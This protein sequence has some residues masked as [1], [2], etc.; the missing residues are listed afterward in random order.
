MRGPY[1]RED[2]ILPLLPSLPPSLP[3]PSPYIVNA[4]PTD[5]LDILVTADSVVLSWATSIKFAR[6][7]GIMVVMFNV[8]ISPA[9]AQTPFLRTVAGG[10]SDVVTYGLTQTGL[11]PAGL[12]HDVSIIAV[13]STPS[14]TSDEAQFSFTLQS[15]EQGS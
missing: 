13:Y 5:V 9:G 2:I 11:S 10:S 12:S 7:A 1:H 3:P 15:E 6:G 8:T 4:R 14:I